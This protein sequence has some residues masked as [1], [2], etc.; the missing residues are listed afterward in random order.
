MANPKMPACHT[1][2]APRSESSWA[3]FFRTQPTDTILQ[4][5]ALRRF[6]CRF[7][8]I[9]DFNTVRASARPTLVLPRVAVWWFFVCSHSVK[10]MLDLEA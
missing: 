5:P 2:N 4:L 9:L 6:G 10:Q 8:Q 3:V 7:G 1:S